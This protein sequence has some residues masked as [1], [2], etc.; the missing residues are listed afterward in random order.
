VPASQS[1]GLSWF[2]LWGDARALRAGERVTIPAHGTQ[3]LV[4]DSPDHALAAIA[5]LGKAGAR[6]ALADPSYDLKTP[7]PKHLHW[8]APA[9]SAETAP[10][11]VAV[12]GGDFEMRVEHRRRESGCY[13]QGADANALWGDDFHDTITHKIPSHVEPFAIGATAVTNAEYLRFVRASG[14]R[15]RDP[16]RFLLQIP[17]LADGSLPATAPTALAEL[18]VTYVSLQDARAYARWAGARLPTEAE[19]QW[20]AEGAGRSNPWPWGAQSPNAALANSS[21]RIAAASAYAAGA[22]P[23]GVVG[24]TGNVWEWT[25]SEWSDGHDRFAML[26]GG[27]DLPQPA[28]LSEWMLPRGPH[29]NGYHAK[30]FLVS[31]GLDRSE[32][33]GFR[34]I[35]LRSPV[36]ADI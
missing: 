2:A 6:A 30:Y 11:F 8:P 18:P 16:A 35:R 36:G 14:Y 32:T 13:S 22:T 33:I 27:T 31:E 3:A 4:L 23:Q 28:N 19:W 34:V 25:E 21:G 26:R 5:A 24:L 10:G 29:Q 17:R 7:E 15:P 9:A 1:A 20:A 12:P